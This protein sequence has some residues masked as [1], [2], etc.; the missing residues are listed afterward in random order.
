[1][2][3][4]PLL[5]N[6]FEKA[7][8][9]LLKLAD[10]EAE[11]VVPS[12]LTL[13]LNWHRSRIV[14]SQL[15]ALASTLLE[16][17]SRF[18]AKV[19]Q[20]VLREIGVGNFNNVVEGDGDE[21]LHK[22]LV[23]AMEKTNEVAREAFVRSVLFLEMR[24][25]SDNSHERN[26]H[27]HADLSKSALMEYLGL[28]IT[29]MRLPEIQSFLFNGTSVKVDIESEVFSTSEERLLYIQRLLW[30]AVGWEPDNA[31]D[32]MKHLMEEGN[33]ELMNDNEVME[34][35]MKYTSSV[36][37]A[38]TNASMGSDLTESM[39]TT[40]GTTR[41]VNVTYS[42]KVVTSETIQSLSAPT[43]NSMNE[44]KHEQ[45]SL[46]QKA[47]RDVAKLRQDIHDEFVSLPPDE[48]GKTL[49]KAKQAQDAFLQKVMSTPPGAERVMLMKSIDF[50]TQKLLIIHKMWATV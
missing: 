15:T 44:H 7:C 17:E 3:P 41:V 33:S 50:E 1:M 11:E 19:V 37:V 31:S 10:E 38:V 30:K 9:Q 16:Y 39:S 26:L 28:A 46:E 4:L 13:N 47:Q 43:S 24:D 12:E 21:E 27:T 23:T 2:I 18:N 48:Q 29:A 34:T 32:Q 49:A 14:E 40:D 6:Y 36:R 45:Q 20:D 25:S 35:V 8:K 5:L 22:T 42:E